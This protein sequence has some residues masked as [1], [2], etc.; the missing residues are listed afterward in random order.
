MLH[1]EKSPQAIKG[2]FKVKNDRGLH[3]RPSAELVKCAATFKSHI[4]LVYR[5]NRV[6]AKSILGI[7]MLAAAKGARIQIEAEGADAP[8]AVASLVDLASKSF[9]MHY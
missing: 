9:N 5:K 2:C 8:Q 4:T 7:L 1:F 3:T 6:N